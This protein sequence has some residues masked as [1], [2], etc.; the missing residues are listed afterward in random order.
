MAARRTSSRAVLGFTLALERMGKPPFSIARIAST[1]GLVDQVFSDSTGEGDNGEIDT[2]GPWNEGE[3]C[4]FIESP[5]IQKMRDANPTE[6]T[7]TTIRNSTV[8]AFTATTASSHPGQ[9][10]QRGTWRKRTTVFYTPHPQLAAA[11][12]RDPRWRQ[13]SAVLHGGHRATSVN[14]HWP[15][16]RPHRKQRRQRE[17]NQFHR[18]LEFDEGSSDG[19]RSFVVAGPSAMLSGRMASEIRPA[20]TDSPTIWIFAARSQP[21]ELTRKPSR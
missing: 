16:R 2:R 20:I 9:G 1:P 12:R 6:T 19:T 15:P 7:K 4:Q 13:L 11:L 18:S 3:S 8:N 14:T 5:A 21:S 17:I 10:I